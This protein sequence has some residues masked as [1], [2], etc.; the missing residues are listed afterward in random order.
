MSRKDKKNLQIL[1][2]NLFRLMLD[3][4]LP[5]VISTLLIGIQNFVDGIVAGQFLGESAFA[6]IS[7][8]FPIILILSGLANLIGV[9][10]A[11]VFSRAIGAKDYVTKRKVLN[12]LFLLT[13]I[14][15]VICTFLGY[16][17]SDTLIIFIGGRNEIFQYASSYLKVI[18]LGTV[19]FLSAQA[20]KIVI[21]A[22]GNI[23]LATL[24]TGI[25]VGLNIFLNLFFIE[26][27]DLGIIGIAFATVISML[28][29]CFLNFKYIIKN[30]NIN[31]RLSTLLY[32]NYFSIKLVKQVIF[33]GI[34]AMFI[35]MLTLFQHGLIFK[36]IAL[37]GT[38]RDIAFMGACLKVFVLCIDI[39]LGFSIGFQPIAGI[40]Y[41]AKNYSRIKNSLI[42][43]AVSGAFILMLLWLY[44]QLFSE[45]IIGLLLPS[46]NLAEKD[47]LYFRATIFLI[48][49]F[50]FA[51]CSITLFQNIG[52][53]LLA[54][55]LVLSRQI[56][57]F[58]PILYLC[59]KLLGITG[60][61]F[62][63]I[64]V[65]I[66]I[67]ALVGVFTVIELQKMSLKS[68]H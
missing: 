39:A 5:G 3:L 33:I 29:L 32:G 22:E 35:D 27:I 12:N 26:V 21:N 62:S 61:Y 20:I 68:I 42:L 47:I 18:F 44:M 37:N 24:Y 16:T 51:F 36:A 48:P 63:L 11:S 52:K 59:Q 66:L 54:A 13:L 50:P 34:S 40:N 10:S 41:G 19:F 30:Q 2:K 45:A 67:I 8:T 58:V 55:M 49:F 64:I 46:F 28:V 31:L 65:D 53:G 23:G 25:S 43:F 17:F 7:I 4:A 60:I 38:D 15:S 6:A 56:L 57:L 14:A 1:N 9:G